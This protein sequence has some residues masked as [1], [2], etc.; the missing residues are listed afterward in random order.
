MAG[1][2]GVRAGWWRGV[3]AAMAGLVIAC[4]IFADIAT[5]ASAERRAALVI[6]IGRY[7]TVTPLVNPPNDARAMAGALRDL[8]FEVVDG[9]DLDRAAFTRAL[10]DFARIAD[11]AELA[12]VFYAGHGVQVDNENWLLPTD[13]R[14][15]SRLD[16]E[17]EAIGAEALL[18]AMSGARG[19]ILLLD[20]CRD[21]PFKE[22][23]M[24]TAAGRS[25]GRGLARLNVQDTGTLIA[26]A[27]SPEAVASDG[28]GGASNSPFT[29]A[30]LA[31]IR[32]PG[33]EIRQMLTR[34]RQAVIAATE[35]RQTPWEN[36][37]LVADVYLAGPP[38]QTAGETADVVLWRAIEGSDDPAAYDLFLRRFP[39]SPHAAA[40]AEKRRVLVAA[41]PSPA[42]PAAGSA[43]PAAGSALPATESPAPPSAR[44]CPT[45][46]EVVRLPA[47]SFLMGASAEDRSATDNERP[48]HRAVVGA[49]AMTRFPITFAEW[50]ACVAD[51]GCPPVPDDGGW[52]RGQRPVV[53]V[54][55]TDANAY[56]AWLSARTGAVWR[57]P[58]ETEW[59]YAARAGT[60]TTRFW[61]DDP[62]AAC[63]FANVYDTAALAPGRTAGDASAWAGT[64]HGCS[65]G[66]AGTAPVGSFR[67]NPFG[68]SDMIGNVWQWVG[69]CWRDDYSAASGT[70]EPAS[71][72]ECQERVLRGG[73]WLSQPS[74]AR[75][76]ARMRSDPVE[77][78]TNF[79]FRLV[80]QLP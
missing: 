78:D 21:N 45:C 77:R 35:G 49:F 28:G 37:S 31:H 15:E 67:P 61:G 62:A 50:D 2:S 32:T 25:V 58:S 59:E 4:V 20:A 46:P 68:L 51:G 29:T 26:F 11:G 52:G 5:A 27:T 23:F 10:R 53:N 9:I 41:L 22:G 7:A 8:G 42:L 70:A 16:L 43:L 19:R 55:W 38:A 47:G 80:R 72:P 56:A 30:L 33:L 65:D 18:R 64:P 66:Y 48:A 74:A 6:G 12:L 57:L 44:D 39:D 63:G 34:A 76:S 14:L 54:S 71:D 75:S 13:V 36:S 69:D 79:G 17:F 1:R 3:A 24:A 40:A 60:D 73:S